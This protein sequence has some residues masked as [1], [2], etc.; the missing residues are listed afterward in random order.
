MGQYVKLWGTKPNILVLKPLAQ[1]AQVFACELCVQDTMVNQTN[2]MRGF[3][4]RE[5]ALD[6]ACN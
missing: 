4:I 1:G 3:K 6:S 5:V 2:S